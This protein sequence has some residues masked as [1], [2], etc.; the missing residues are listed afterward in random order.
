MRRVQPSAGVRLP[1]RS[2]AAP[3]LYLHRPG[4]GRH[5]DKTCLIQYERLIQYECLIQYEL[6]RKVAKYVKDL[7]WIV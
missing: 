3:R 5:D 7:P 6:V 4:R 2:A 1:L